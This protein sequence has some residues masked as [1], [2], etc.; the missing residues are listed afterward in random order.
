MPPPSPFL[1]LRRARGHQC[2]GHQCQRL[3]YLEVVDYPEDAEDTG[4]THPLTD[5]KAESVVSLHAIA[6]V[7]TKD[8]M[9]VPVYIH[10]HCLTALLDSGSTHNF[11]HAELMSRIGLATSGANLR[12]TVANGDRVPCGVE[13]RNVAMQIGQDDFTISCF[14]IDLDSL[15]LVL[16]V[17]ILQTLG[18][19]LW[20][21]EDLCMAFYQN[22]RRIF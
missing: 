16:G 21:F 20:D 2:R 7:R 15:D 4:E 10:G 8:T 1:Q 22:G 12:V 18:P 5:D 6:G 19:I 14:G 11:I 13:A 9:Q 3:F 17:D